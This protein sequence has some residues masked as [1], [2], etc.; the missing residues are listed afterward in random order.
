MAAI[1]PQSGLAKR[2]TARNSLSDPY[3]SASKSERAL[4]DPRAQSPLQLGD[5]GRLGGASQAKERPRR[6]HGTTVRR[7]SMTT[8][9]EQLVLLLDHVPGDSAQLEGHIWLVLKLSTLVISSRKS[10]AISSRV[11]ASIIL[12]SVNESPID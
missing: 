6:L 8:N 10:S 5:F 2:A 9:V 11:M 1:R 7:T 3:S 4:P 12:A